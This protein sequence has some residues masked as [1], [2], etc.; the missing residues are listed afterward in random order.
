MISRRCRRARPAARLHAD[1]AELAADGRRQLGGR[2][3]ALAPD[4]PGHGMAAERRPA[5]FAA[6]AGYVRALAGERCTLAGYSMGGRIALYTAL[7]LPA[8]VERLVL[9]GASPG[10]A[11]A[12]EREERRRADDALADRIEA[13]GVDGVRGRV[14]RAG[15]VRRPARAGRGGRA[16]RPPAQHRDR[17]GRRA[18]RARDR[19]DA[20]AMGPARPPDDPGH[21]GR[22][23]AR[24]QV[25]GDRRADGERDPGLP[26]RRGCRAPATPSSSSAR[27]P[28]RRRSPQ[29]DRPATNAAAEIAIRSS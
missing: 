21:P 16:R 9:V 28:S 11:D 19:R 23:R 8:D 24:R 13:I 1:A 22:R 5:S 18:A 4:L 7:A 2:Y 15:A 10:L 27:R 25:P 17:P 29:R 20:V 12:A 6:C 14:G 3:R 26:R